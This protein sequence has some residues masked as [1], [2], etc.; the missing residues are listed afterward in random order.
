MDKQCD[1]ITILNKK[2]LTQINNIFNPFF[3]NIRIAINLLKNEQNL[4]HINF[5][6]DLKNMKKVDKIS[7]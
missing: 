5:N 2:I 1:Q 3:K 7:I 6:I 4:T